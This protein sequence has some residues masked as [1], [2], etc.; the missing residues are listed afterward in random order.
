MRRFG[1]AVLGGLVA[2]GL[3]AAVPAAV[4]AAQPACGDTLTASTTLTADL[5]CSAYAGTALTL[6]KNGI[7]LNL[8]GH[9]LWGP[10]GSDG[11]TGVDNDGH[12]NDVIKNGTIANFTY[13]V[14]LDAAI[15]STVKNLTIAAEVADTSDYGV[16]QYGGVGNIIDHLTITDA[17]YGL[18]LYDAAETTVTSN[19]ITG[20]GY[21]VYLEYESNDMLAGNYAEYSYAG[22]YDDYSSHQVYQGNNAN[23]T[24]DSGTYGFYFDCDDYGWVKALNNTTKGNSSYGMYLYYCYDDNNQTKG[25]LVKGNTSNDNSGS[26]FGDYYSIHSLWTSNTAKRNGGD[27]FYMDY[28]GVDVF[29]YNVANRNS[30]DGIDIADNYGTGYGNF[31]NFSYNTANNNSSYGMTAAYGVPGGTGNAATGNGSQNCYN[32]RCN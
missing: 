16:E 29:Q 13:G 12:K 21:G 9:T 14:Y 18:Y 20:A 32:I 24:P 19:H 23:G 2:L 17:Y 22:F 10:T 11:Y 6:G 30:D 4:F 8:G 28:P 25:S 26:G 7:T 15:D 3:V 27:G 31:K 5:D 1:R